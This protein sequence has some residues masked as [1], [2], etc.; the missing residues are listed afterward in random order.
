MSQICQV[1]EIL[2][3]TVDTSII[4]LMEPHKIAELEEK[5]IVFLDWLKTYSTTESS[6]MQG[7]NSLKFIVARKLVALANS[8][9]KQ[10]RMR[11]VRHLGSIKNLDN[12]HY[13]ILARMCTAQTAVGLA[14]TPGIDKRFFVEPPTKY[15][16]CDH[17]G[18]VKNMEDFI[19]HLNSKSNHRCL[20]KF[21]NRVFTET[22]VSIFIQNKIK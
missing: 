17:R 7:W 20:T 14:R 16:S 6:I 4:E 19:L 2:N 15:S 21:V 5:H 1:Q 8:E 22:H 11:A 9:N 18:L 12:W 13:S 10:V 3:N